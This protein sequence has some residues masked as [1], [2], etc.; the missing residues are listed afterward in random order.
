MN[1][2]SHTAVRSSTTPATGCARCSPH[3]AGAVDAAI[4]AQRLLELPVRMGI[5]TGEAELR[6]GEYFGP[7]LNRTA[8]LMAAGH[9]GQVLLDGATASLAQRHRSDAVGS[10]AITRYRQNQS[11]SSRSRASG[12]RTEFL[13]LKTVDQI[14]GNLRSI[15]TSII[16]READVAEVQGALKAHRL[17]T[18]TGVGGVGKTRLALEVATRVVNDYADGVW[19][20]ELAPVGDPQRG[21]RSRRGH[22]GYHTTARPQ[23]VREHR[24]G[25]RRPIKAA[26]VRQLRTH[27]RCGGRHH[28]SDL[29]P[30][31]DRCRLGNQPRRPTA[32][33]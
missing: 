33:R 5:A 21:T 12:L 11:T 10:E 7:V 25:S 17:V 9:G 6:G 8:R 30:L 26:G 4:M 29:R 22:H 1:R 19:V 23:H 18:L 16:G 13:P 24:S 14:P 28:R 32:Q 31:I 27:P 20:I 15:T 2:S 3:L